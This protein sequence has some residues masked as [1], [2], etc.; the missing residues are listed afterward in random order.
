MERTPFL[1]FGAEVVT[2]AET[3]VVTTGSGA[4]SR[5]AERAGALL[6]KSSSAPGK[7]A[8]RVIVRLLLRLIHV[9][10]GGK[11]ALLQKMLHMQ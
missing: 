6:R 8:L 4:T 3:E 2:G 7:L 1:L 9:L 5:T 10:D 11:T